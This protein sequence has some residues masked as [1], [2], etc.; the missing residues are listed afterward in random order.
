MVTV[1]GSGSENF[2]ETL[3]TWYVAHVCGGHS[4]RI[5]DKATAQSFVVESVVEIIAHLALNLDP[6]STIEAEQAVGK[7]V[8]S[9]EKVPSQ[10]RGREAD[11]GTG[12]QPIGRDSI[13]S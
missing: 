8:Q 11:S 3:T 6:C 10:G 4:V 1:V 13:S 5:V 7:I 2:T 12:G 9:Q